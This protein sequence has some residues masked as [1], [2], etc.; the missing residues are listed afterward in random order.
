MGEAKRRR[1]HD[2]NYGKPKFTAFEVNGPHEHV[3]LNF[4]IGD[5]VMTVLDGCMLCGRLAGVDMDH[6]HNGVFHGVT[7]AD[8][9][10]GWTY[11]Y[12]RVEEVP[13]SDTWGFFEDG[14]ANHLCKDCI[15]KHGRPLPAA[16][17]ARLDKLGEKIWPEI[18][19]RYGC[20]C[21]I[22]WIDV[23]HATSHPG[24]VQRQ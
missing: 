14:S 18:R 16:I 7:V 10:G 24:G 22:K 20:P 5:R 8:A 3:D 17:H 21:E 11:V 1:A 4:A 19:L 2:P 15:A 23:T 12:A 9:D 6:R 13:N